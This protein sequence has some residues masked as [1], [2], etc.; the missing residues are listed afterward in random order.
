M[1]T[2]EAKLKA[3]EALLRRIAEQ[4]AAG[5]L[6]GAPEGTAELVR[7]VWLLNAA[8]RPRQFRHAVQHANP[9]ADE[10]QALAAY[11]FERWVENAEDRA[12]L[13]AVLYCLALQAGGGASLPAAA[14]IASSVQQWLA[15]APG[16]GMNRTA[17]ELRR[18]RTTLDQCRSMEE[19]RISGLLGT[20]SGLKHQ[21][22]QEPPR[23]EVIAEV[24]LL[25]ASVDAALK[26][27]QPGAEAASYDFADLLLD[28]SGA[29]TAP[30]RPEL[31]KPA[32]EGQQ[33]AR[34]AAAGSLRADPLLDEN[35]LTATISTLVAALRAANGPV[36]TVRLPNT[37]LVLSPLEFQSL[38]TEYPATEVSFRAELNVVVRRAAGLRAYIQEELE[39]YRTR[40]RTDHLWKKH[41]ESAVYFAPV[42]DRLIREVETFTGECTR[43][44]LRKKA[45]D[46]ATVS[47]ELR[48]LRA[49][50][51]E[52]QNS[53]SEEAVLA[54]A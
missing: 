18:A 9:S 28:N 51:T 12:K 10:L 7:W 39:L 6:P 33:P 45:E 32:A 46:L 49:A 25:Y 26:R 27:V 34:A 19:I 24:V 8:V 13:E 23:A 30:G 31:R 17:D 3:A 44:G 21:I 41:L 5:P 16:R 1:N 43:R 48:K 54:S 38:Q 22:G 14:M 29:E 40:R 50:I 36:T 2:D 53:A 52:V 47:E 20:I 15:V 35:R 42:A 11:L 4:L 37:E